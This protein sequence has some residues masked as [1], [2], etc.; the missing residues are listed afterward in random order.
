[1]L[2][3]NV[4]WNFKTNVWT[5]GSMEITTKF[6]IEKEGDLWLL[7]DEHGYI[8]GKYKTLELLM[9]GLKDKEEGKNKFYLD[10]DYSASSFL[11]VNSNYAE[12]LKEMRS[13]RSAQPPSEVVIRG[14]VKRQSPC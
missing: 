3:P 2:L 4:L 13:S 8:V 1:M 9:K 6:S 5:E 10:D 7:M 11:S 14:T 12:A